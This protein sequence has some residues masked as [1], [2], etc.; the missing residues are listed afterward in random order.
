MSRSISPASAFKFS[1]RVRAAG[2]VLA[3]LALS[4]ILAS[5]CGKA[6]IAKAQEEARQAQAEAERVTAELASAKSELES[7]LSE[8]PQSA[9]ASDRNSLRELRSQVETANSDAA[10]AIAARD[11][12]E[13]GPREG[14][15][16]G[17]TGVS[18]AGV[19]PRRTR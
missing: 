7:E 11:A 18:Q 14:V 10:T 6:E 9:R 8:S 4:A 17:G 2:P 5:G 19:A 12:L 3:G 15:G 13:R 1:N 16:V